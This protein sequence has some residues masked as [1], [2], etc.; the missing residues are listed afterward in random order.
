MEYYYICPRCGKTRFYDENDKHICNFCNFS[1]MIAT[2]FEGSKMLDIIMYEPP[3]KRKQI[4]ELLR[5]KYTLNS[6][7]FDNNLYQQ[8]I[9]DEKLFN[10]QNKDDEI[11]QECFQSQQSNNIPKCPTC[12]STNIEKISLTS[13]A[14]GAGLFGIFSKTARSQFKCNNCGYKW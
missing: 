9:N 10:I 11:E 7:S 6:V 14:I 5:K 4:N 2:E 12:G 8:M 13:K 3:S 1:E